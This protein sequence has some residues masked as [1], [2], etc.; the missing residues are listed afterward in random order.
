IAGLPP[1]GANGPKE[2]KV[3]NS[4]PDDAR[5]VVIQSLQ[6]RLVVR[7]DGCPRER[8]PGSKTSLGVELAIDYALSPRRSQQQPAF[9]EHDVLRNARLSVHRSADA[10]ARGLTEIAITCAPRHYAFHGRVR[11]NSHATGV[12]VRSIRPPSVRTS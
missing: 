6:A 11:L 2:I 4:S 7:S 9:L 1:N 10:E 12:A 3:N 5:C 8:S